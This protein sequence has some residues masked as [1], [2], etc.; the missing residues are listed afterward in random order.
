MQCS[1][2]TCT[3]VW[4]SWHAL[5]AAVAHQCHAC[6]AWRRRACTAGACARGACACMHAQ[7]WRRA[8]RQRCRSRSLW[9]RRRRRWRR[10]PSARR[11]G[12]SASSPGAH[13]HAHAHPHTRTRTCH[14]MGALRAARAVHVPHAGGHLHHACTVVVHRGRRRSATSAGVPPPKA[15]P[16]SHTAHVHLLCAVCCGGRRKGDAL[17]FF[18]MDIMGGVGDR[19]A[20]HAS[21]PTLKVRTYVGPLMG[22]GAGGGPKGGW[23]AFAYGGVQGSAVC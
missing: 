15:Q 7:M 2:V 21:C 23:G 11:S 17:L 13:P 12:A 8:A 4:M 18:D 9:T 19:H 6:H 3:G 1:G 16:R 14:A 5:H 20:L 22:A 10:R